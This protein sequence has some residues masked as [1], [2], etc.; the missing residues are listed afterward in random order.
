MTMFHVTSQG[1][2]TVDTSSIK[3]DLEEAYKS[4]LGANLNLESSTPQGQ[5]IINDTAS[6]TTAMNEVVNIANN[7]SIYTAKGAALD[8]VAAF[9]GY[10]RKQGV[11]TTVYIT[12]TGT[13]GTVIFAG[14]IVSDGTHKYITLD[15]ITIASGTGKVWAQCT[16]KGYILCPPNTVTTIETLITGWDTVDN[17]NA[18]ISGYATETD[19]EF[20]QRITANWL[21]IRARSILGA[22]IDNVAALDNVISVLGRENPTKNSVTVDGI[23]FEPNS[24]YLCIL[25]GND[26]DIAKIISS[27]KTLGAATNGNTSVMYQDTDVGQN[28][29]YLIQRPSVVVLAVQIEYMANNYTSADVENQIKDLILQYIANNPFKIGQTI[30]GN[31]LSQALSDFNQINLL[32]FKIKKTS[33]VDYSDYINLTISEVASLDSAHITFSEVS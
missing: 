10:Y 9:Y 7:F 15:T 8:V 26:K 30:S 21:N 27:Q 14:S 6:L 22:I 33:D 24:I 25:G 2:I 16:E 20:R 28:I 19:N 3:Q 1:V 23:T 31:I 29:S 17:V 12:V 11:A 4:A 5:M 18:G 32:S 13:N